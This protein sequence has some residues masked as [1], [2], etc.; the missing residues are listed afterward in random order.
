MG[1]VIGVRFQIHTFTKAPSWSEAVHQLTRP[2]R[3]LECCSAFVEGL[4]EQV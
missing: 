2:V 3:Y 1:I 4:S